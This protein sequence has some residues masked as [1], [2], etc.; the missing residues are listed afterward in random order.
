MKKKLGRPE[1][2]QIGPKNTNHLI[3]NVYNM[4]GFGF[5]K[6]LVEK[7]ISQVFFPTYPILL[8]DDEITKFILKT[9]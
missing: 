7:K 4:I 6:F 2:A 1:M 5:H 3:S 8:T 9:H